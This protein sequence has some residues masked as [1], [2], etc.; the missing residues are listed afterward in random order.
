MKL[1]YL[2]ETTEDAERAG[3]DADT[4]IERTGLDVYLKHIFPNVDD[5]VH[6]KPFG[7]SDKS[8]S[9][10]RP[11]Y[12]SESL[13]L[14]VEFDGLPHYQSKHQVE[15]DSESERLYTKA[16][17]KVVR[18]PFFIQL[19]SSVIE[20]LFGVRDI[21]GFDYDVPSFTKNCGSLPVDMCV[22]GIVRMMNEFMSIAP[23]QLYKNRSYFLDNKMLDCYN[24]T[25]M[26]TYEFLKKAI[27]Q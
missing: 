23:E 14:I 19:T 10:K 18:I 15:R 22:H 20:R 3:V 8:V 11:D 6:D 9:R 13:K 12:K 2:R 21:Q 5:F 25:N 17:Y 16:G 1:G 27:G 7:G 26:S 24:L 4:G